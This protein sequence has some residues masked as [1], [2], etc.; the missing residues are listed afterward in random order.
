MQDI[1]HTD[2]EVKFSLIDNLICADL[3]DRLNAF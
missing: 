1:V 3:Y 2:E